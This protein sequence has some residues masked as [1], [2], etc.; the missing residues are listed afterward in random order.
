M[1]LLVREQIGQKGGCGSPSQR[2]INLFLL[3]PWPEIVQAKGICA[4]A[5][6]AQELLSHQ[7]PALNLSKVTRPLGL[8][9]IALHK[10][11]PHFYSPSTC[12]NTE[13]IY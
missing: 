8:D 1:V 2:K 7:D 11:T 9:T 10:L 6:F 13:L 3:G 4:Q 5:K 12:P